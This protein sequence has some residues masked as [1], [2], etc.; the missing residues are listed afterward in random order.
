M[1]LA[2]IY[3][4]PQREGRLR[5]A[6]LELRRRPAD[7]ARTQKPR[8]HSGRERGVAR[9]GQG[10]A[11]PRRQFR[12]P[13][14]RLRLHAGD[15]HGQRPSRRLLPP[16]GLPGAGPRSCAGHERLRRAPRLAAHAVGP[17]A[18][19]D[20]S[21]AGRRGDRRHRPW[22]GAGRALERPDVRAGDLLG[23]PAFAAG[24]G[25][26]RRRR[27]GSRPRA[28]ASPRCCTTRPNM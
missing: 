12:R 21:F 24:R 8:R 27:A 2:R 6:P 11:R 28:C 26:V 13:D 14:H 5:K 23:R 18:R 7:P 1:A 3:S 4:R 17:A 16:R 9:H 22:A 25:P 19:P 10:P 20:R 15:R